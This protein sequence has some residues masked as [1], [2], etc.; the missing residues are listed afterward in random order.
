MLREPLLC[1]GCRRCGCC[2]F[3]SQS[4]TTFMAIEHGQP[5][6]AF[7]RLFRTRTDS[8]DHVFVCVCM[9]LCARAFV[10][11]FFCRVCLFLLFIWILRKIILNVLSERGDNNCDVF[12]VSRYDSFHS[13]V[14]FT[15]INTIRRFCYIRQCLVECQWSKIS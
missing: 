1:C 13:N 15:N 2:C 6:D 8:E 9:V 5:C 3:F 10:V 7:I 12:D 4:I 14:L 11:L